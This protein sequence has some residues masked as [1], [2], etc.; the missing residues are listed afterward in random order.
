MVQNTE[1]TIPMMDIQE[2]KINPTPLQQH[3]QYGSA[4]SEGITY[5]KPVSSQI[6]IS[7]I[8]LV[9]TI[10]FF[11]LVSSVVGMLFVVV[12]NSNEPS[13]T[14]ESTADNSLAKAIPAKSQKEH[15]GKNE[16]QNG[17][18]SQKTINLSVYNT[19]SNMF[20]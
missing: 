11:G 7:S 9:L 13:R 19:T 18:K 4:Q 17:M 2:R 1:L 12:N 10:T 15:E 6:T 8:V 20:G 16:A 14:L 5:F 3:I